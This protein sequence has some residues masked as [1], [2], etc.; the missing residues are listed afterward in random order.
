MIHTAHAIMRALEKEE[1]ILLILH[2]QN[3]S[4]GLFNLGYQK[5]C[6]KIM[7]FCAYWHRRNKGRRASK[8]IAAAT[9]VDIVQDG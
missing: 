9:L 3:Y 2:K 5:K 1:V 8:E 4:L 6:R 7:M